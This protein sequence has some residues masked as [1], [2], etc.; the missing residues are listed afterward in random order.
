M[1]V[2]LCPSLNQGLQLEQEKMHAD[3]DKL[4]AEE[5]EKERRLQKLM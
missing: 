4:K 2:P 3:Y 5:Q 1:G